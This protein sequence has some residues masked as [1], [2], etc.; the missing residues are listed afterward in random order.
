MFSHAET[1]GIEEAKKDAGQA[2]HA[3][4]Q[5]HRDVPC[6]SAHAELATSMSQKESDCAGG[7]QQQLRSSHG[8]ALLLSRLL[9][10]LCRLNLVNDA[11]FVNVCNRAGAAMS[12]V[13]CRA[14]LYDLAMMLANRHYFAERSEDQGLI[15]L[16][17]V[18]R[19]AMPVMENEGHRELLFKPVLFACSSFNHFDEPFLTLVTQKILSGRA[20]HATPSSDAVGVDRGAAFTALKDSAAADSTSV[21]PAAPLVLSTLQSSNAEPRAKHEPKSVLELL[22]VSELADL[23]RSFG[24]L[25]WRT[26]VV[27]GRGGVSAATAEG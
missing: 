17:D 11:S 9:L 22:T 14:T 1:S 23:Y 2:G 24:Q 18:I 19:A 8:P 3:I 25:Q 21:T 6:T 4:A 15:L 16:A 12:G 7:S 13:R 26:A 10:T 27:S 20:P 5:K